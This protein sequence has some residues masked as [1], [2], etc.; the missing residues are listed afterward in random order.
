MKTFAL[1]VS[2]LRHLI[3]IA[4]GCAVLGAALPATAT[5]IP[6]SSATGTPKTPIGKR[7]AFFIWHVGNTAYL[8]TTGTTKAGHK[9]YGTIVVTGG[10]VSNLVRHQ[11]E[12]ADKTEILGKNQVVF[13]F[14]TSLGVDGIHFL[15]TG[16]TKLKLTASFD[17]QAFP[18]MIVYGKNAIPVKNDPVTFDLTK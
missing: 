13:H 2:R 1:H 11:L 16:G 7:V 18:N 12:K 8:Y 17:G 10:T 15:I 4:L 6:W 14:D 9:D 3:V 5:D